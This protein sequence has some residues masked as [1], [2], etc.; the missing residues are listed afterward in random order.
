VDKRAAVE[1]VGA[2]QQPGN[3]SDGEV[4]RRPPWLLGAIVV[5]ALTAVVVVSLATR[6]AS[7]AADDETTPETSIA[8]STSSVSP[9]TTAAANTVA[10]DPPATVEVIAPEPTIEIVDGTEVEF[11]ATR[12]EVIDAL[13]PSGIDGWLFSVDERGQLTRIDLTT[14]EEARINLPQTDS[15]NLFIGNAIVQVGDKLLRPA[16]G[17]LSIVDVT[18][19]STTTFKHEFGSAVILANDDETVWLLAVS[20]DQGSSL[21][22]VS[23]LTGEITEPVVVDPIRASFAIGGAARG[24][25]RFTVPFVGTWEVENGT[26]RQL[27]GSILT[28]VNGGTLEV[29][30]GDNPTDCLTVIHSI[31]TGIETE[32]EIG[33]TTD[34]FGTSLSPSLDAVATR[35]KVVRTDGSIIELNS[36]FDGPSWIWSSDGRFIV[37]A[38]LTV[39]DTTGELETFTVPGSSRSDFLPGQLLV[40]RSDF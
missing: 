17:Q 23:M 40:L 33:A 14:G 22:S 7:V 31:E 13:P 39:V 12:P 6:D 19:L 15:S 8:E 24:V 36:N 37:N 30:C 11:L 21:F 25:L 1:V 3:S 28:G 26:F 29:R 4:D 16:A 2:D 32:I 35:A 10:G 34:L 18:T 27:D 9:T 20:Q 38:N 5:A